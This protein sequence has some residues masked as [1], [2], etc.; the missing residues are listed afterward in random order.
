MDGALTDRNINLRGRNHRLRLGAVFY[1]FSFAYAAWAAQPS[2]PLAYRAFTFLPFLVAGLM[3]FQATFKT[4]VM[5]AARGER[6]TDLGVERVAQT[7]QRR[8]DRARA[9]RVVRAATVTAA[10]GTGIL[11]LLP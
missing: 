8:D 4:C 6:E 9:W 11:L 3:V 1:A 10:L 7:D 5:R 2:T